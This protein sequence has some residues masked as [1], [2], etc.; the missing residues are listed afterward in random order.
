V[1]SL[2]GHS[3]VVNGF[4][5]SNRLITPSPNPVNNAANIQSN[6]AHPGAIGDPKLFP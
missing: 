3:Q 5:A 4:T 2:F 1:S 6:Q